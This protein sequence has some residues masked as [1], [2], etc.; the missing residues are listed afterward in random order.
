MSVPYINY[1]DLDEF[2]TLKGVCQLLELDKQTLQEKC[3][4]Y[5]I[6]PQRNEVGDWGLSR[7]NLRKLHNTLYYED[8]KK[9]GGRRGDDPWA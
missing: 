2:Y 7:Y 6:S 4:Q 3:R 9:V 8:K 1:K 5:D